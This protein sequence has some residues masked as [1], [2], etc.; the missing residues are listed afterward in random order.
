MVSRL[1][2][3]GC[4]AGFFLVASLKGIWVLECCFCSV[5]S[6][7]QGQRNASYCFGSGMCFFLNF[8]GCS[9]RFPGHEW[10]GDVFTSSRFAGHGSINYLCRLHQLPYSCTWRFHRQFS[11]LLR[12]PIL[13][14]FS[15]SIMPRCAVMLSVC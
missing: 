15:G 13:N 2:P 12:N 5:E 14:R 7:L 11:L 4:G 1:Q 8:S 6:G 10:G 9:K 3:P